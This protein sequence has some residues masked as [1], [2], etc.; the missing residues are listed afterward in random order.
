M[1]FEISSLSAG[2]VCTV[3]WFFS[4]LN[5]FE[6]ENIRSMGKLG[7]IL[8]ASHLVLGQCFE[9]LKGKERKDK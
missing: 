6:V 1:K 4:N 3:Q 5:A 7:V 2:W 9:W 8:R